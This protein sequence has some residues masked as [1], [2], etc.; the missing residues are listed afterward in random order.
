MIGWRGRIFRRWMW[1]FLSWGFRCLFI[2][3]CEALFA[4]RMR[5]SR[6]L[7]GTELYDGLDEELHAL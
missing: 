1:R 5:K 3:W 4:H 2:C 6:G 7:E